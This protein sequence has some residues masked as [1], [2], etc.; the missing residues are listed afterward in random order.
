MRKLL[1]EEPNAKAN[2]GYYCYQYYDKGGAELKFLA[3][4]NDHLFIKEIE[5]QGELRNE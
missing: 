5:D 3:D 4:G 1:N 2:C